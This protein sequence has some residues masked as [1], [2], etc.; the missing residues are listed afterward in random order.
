MKTLIIED[1]PVTTKIVA[2]YLIQYGMVIT[3]GSAQE[4]LDIYNDSAFSSTPF[5]LICLDLQLPEYDGVE[6]LNYIRKAEQKSGIPLPLGV[7]IV[8]LTAHDDP[9]TYFDA[10][11]QGC[12][13][14]LTKPL[15]KEKFKSELSRLQLI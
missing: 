15:N 3:A 11:S 14:F 8:I 6:F 2:N 13:A 12:D 10:Q 5:D 7:K 1:D 4:A 9:A